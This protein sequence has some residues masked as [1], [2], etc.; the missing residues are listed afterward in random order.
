MWEGSGSSG[1]YNS[2]K[3]MLKQGPLLELNEVL[4]RRR[5]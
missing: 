2:M 5:L 4:T 3:K 1:P